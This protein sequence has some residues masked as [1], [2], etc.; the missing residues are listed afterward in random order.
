MRHSKNRS[1]YAPGKGFGMNKEQVKA[2]LIFVALLMLAGC[3]VWSA[4]TV[5]DAA[6]WFASGLLSNKF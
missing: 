5:K 3:V 1:N 4:V 6:E 2:L